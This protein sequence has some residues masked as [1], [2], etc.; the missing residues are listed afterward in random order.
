MTPLLC[1]LVSTFTT[2]PLIEVVEPTPTAPA[3]AYASA[4]EPASLDP[5]TPAAPVSDGDFPE[6]EY[7]YIEADYVWMDSD[8]ADDNLNGWNLVG[9]L[10]LPL[11]FFVQGT[12]LD[13]YGDAD[14]T[15]YKLGAGWHFGFLQRFDAYGIL[16]YAHVDVNGTSN[17]TTEDG[18]AG[19]LG[20]RMMLT[21]VIE[22]N[23]RILWADVEDSNSGGGVGGRFYLSEALSLGA[24]YDSFDSQDIVTAGARFEF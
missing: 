11:N 14:I 8:F 15:T 2:Q 22:V 18:P 19:E 10:E 16:S 4:I 9:S 12:L 17:D 20:L 24:N 7:T 3:L 6:L 23:G 5:F 21:K 13:Q 1:L